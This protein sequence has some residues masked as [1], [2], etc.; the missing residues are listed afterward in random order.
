[1][2]TECLLK[3]VVNSLSAPRGGDSAGSEV[4]AGWGEAGAGE[5]EAGC[6]GCGV[7]VQAVKIIPMAKIQIFIFMAAP[8]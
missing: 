3:S 5:S 2:G 1:M 7:A 4:K 6:V 8:L